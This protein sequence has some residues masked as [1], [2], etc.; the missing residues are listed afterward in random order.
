MEC[1]KK[2]FYRRS[3]WLFAG[4]FLIGPSAPLQAKMEDWML[5]GS[6]ATAAAAVVTGM[7]YWCA[8]NDEQALVKGRAIFK[9]ALD[10]FGEEVDTFCSVHYISSS[11]ASLS[12]LTYDEK[13]LQR[14]ALR[15]INCCSGARNHCGKISTIGLALKESIANISKRMQKLENKPY[16]QDAVQMLASMGSLYRKMVDFTPY[17]ELYYSFMNEHRHYFDLYESEVKFTNRY[18]QEAMYVTQYA[19]DPAGFAYGVKLSVGSHTDLYGQFKLIAYKKMLDADIDAVHAQIKALRYAYPNLYAFA[20]R[21]ED[22]LKR[23]RGIIVVDSDYRH[24]VAEKE[25][26]N[27][28]EEM[29]QLAQREAL[30]RERQASAREEANRIERERLRLERKAAAAQ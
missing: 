27:E 30:A 8:E 28:R 19:Y 24:E 15:F 29:L 14:L 21:W 20:V 18:K 25:R 6:L 2:I 23:I 22:L 9:E 10:E 16:D 3:L 17:L 26:Q 1:Q 7:C 4:V 11:D 12:H 13:E 5:Y